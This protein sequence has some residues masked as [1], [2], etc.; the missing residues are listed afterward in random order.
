MVVRG[1]AAPGAQRRVFVGGRP[2]RLRTPVDA[3]RNGLALVPDDRKAKGLVLGASVLHNIA[4]AGGRTRFFIRRA[5]E[6][7]AAGGGSAHCASKRP[8]RASPCCI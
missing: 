3:V 5:Q 2:V 4:L 1:S 8:D 6:E 7:Q